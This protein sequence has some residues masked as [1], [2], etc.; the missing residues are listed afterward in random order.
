MR[1]A[2]SADP[3]KVIAVYHYAALRFA[4]QNNAWSSKACL[5]AASAQ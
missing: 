1:I 4:D 5:L 3:L 2:E